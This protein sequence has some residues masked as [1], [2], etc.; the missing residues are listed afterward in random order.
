MTGLTDKN[1]NLTTP[2]GKWISHEHYSHWEWYQ[3]KNHDKLFHKEE[4]K[5]EEFPL[6]SKTRSRTIFSDIPNP[7]DKEDIPEDVE[8]TTIYTKD[9]WI[10]A[11]GTAPDLY[12]VSPEKKKDG[13]AY[14]SVQMASKQNWTTKRMTHSNELYDL[15]EDIKMGT[16][17]A[18]SEG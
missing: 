7:I 16:A 2:L 11:E 10:I 9:N 1:R 8:P 13:I 5:W 14:L 15:V 12:E 17:I 18:V 6:I 3:P 4:N